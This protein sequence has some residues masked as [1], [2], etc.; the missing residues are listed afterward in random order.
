MEAGAAALLLVA[1]LGTSS[2]SGFYGDSIS[3]APL[4][5]NADGTYK[6]TFYHR[7]NGRNGCQNRSTLLC[8]GGVCT[9]LDRPA[10]VQTDQDTL[11]R[12]CQVEERTT[13]TFQPNGTSFILR[14]SGCCWDNNLEHKSNWE[15]HAELDLGVRSDSYRINNC[16]VTA[17]V[18]S[19]RVSQNCFTHLRL[20]AHDPDEDAV[21]CRFASGAPANF[22]LDESTCTL[23]GSGELQLGQHVFELTVED[24]S[25]KN[26]TLTYADGSTATREAS[27]S[28]LPPLCKLKLQFVVDVLSPT[29][30][31]VAG[32]LL[33][34]FLSRTPSHG[35]VLHASVGQTLQL[36]AEAQ[37]QNAQ[38]QDFQVS[39]PRNVTKVF[40]SGSDG[41]A[42]VT[43]SWTPKES[44]ANQLVPIC[45]A[46]DT[47]TTQ[48]EMRCVIVMVTR[49]AVL[50]GKAF[51]TCLPNK[52]TVALEKA[53]MPDISEE[54]LSLRD[55][56]CTLTTNGTHILGTMSFSTC[57]TK[58]EDKGDYI[59]FKNEIH[60]IVRSNEIIIRRNNV[61]V[62][63]YCEF[64]KTISISN[65]YSL[66]QADYIFTESSFGSFGYSFEIFQDGNFTSR[67]PPNAY[68]VQVKMMEM[69]YMGIQAVSEL[70]NVT[71][72][73]E[74]CKGTPDNNPDN[75]MYYNLIQNGCVK[76]ET[77]KIHPS[78]QTT[79]NFEI[80]A[81]KFN[82]DYDQVYITCNVILCEPGNPFSRCAQGCLSEPSRRRRRDLSMETTGHYITQGPLQVVGPAGPSS[83]AD[84][85]KINAA[86]KSDTAPEGNSP[87]VVPET[88]SDGETWRFREMFSSSITTVVFGSGFVLSLVLLAVVVRY[89]SRKRRAEDRNFLIEDELEK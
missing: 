17:T 52:M 83:H 7:Q 47:A 11:G 78:N 70:P 14:D 22:T 21:R 49:S 40:R 82:G 72:F 36:Y 59:V 5:R 38:I 85:K 32:D 88:R 73:V 16:P 31:C 27:S 58:L 9:N 48:S 1:L 87:G 18:A 69:I 3:L 26:V 65:F 4:Q 45:F 51:V 12:W 10:V 24:F 15:S 28:S 39:G 63:F 13:A 74:S 79:F 89:F 61:K 64:P 80:Q 66:H 29:S 53:S 54:F 20:L 19:L 41:K 30:S 8:D 6:A 60:S 34:M 62:D 67:V 71:L 56:S 75:P 43:L 68:P 46:A 50:Q 25:T 84:H 37:A 2:A 33:P 81:F 23:T 55:P 44:D 35:D 76:D 77:F 42:E 86:P 57:G